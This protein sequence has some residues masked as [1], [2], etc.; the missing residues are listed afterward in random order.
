M[1]G[2]SPESHKTRD[3]ELSLPEGQPE[4]A[5]S[6]LA[7][8]ATCGTPSKS[9]YCSTDCYRVVQRSG[10]DADRFWSKV[11]K[12]D[13]C[14]LWTASRSGGRGQQKYGQFTYLV[15]GAQRHP[16]A[17]VWSWEQANWQ[18]V[19][20]GREILHLCDVKTCVRPDHLQL[21]THAEN[22]KDA[23]VKGFYHVPRPARQKITD[24]QVEQ[25]ISMVRSGLTQVAVAKYFNVTKV[26]I[27][28]IMRGTLRQYRRPGLVS[29]E[30]AS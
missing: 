6:A 23:A 13:G 21:G 27:S 11:N 30:Q 12:T 18:R 9:K 25:A 7:G 29:H 17:H 10:S 3:V 26:T 8:C 1:L 19:P 16:G 4:A 15:D 14:W 22:V 5:G 2:S 24:E 28:R 20:D